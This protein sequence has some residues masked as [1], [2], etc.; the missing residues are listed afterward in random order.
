MTAPGD[1]S[2]SPHLVLLRMTQDIVLAVA[3][4]GGCAFMSLGSDGFWRDKIMVIKAMRRA[5]N[6]WVGLKEAK[7]EVD[8]VV[9]RL[10]REE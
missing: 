9:D 5:G 3:L 8:A 4:D 7:D 2:S 10:S 6:G 1:L